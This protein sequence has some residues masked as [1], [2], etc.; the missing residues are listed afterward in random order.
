MHPRLVRQSAN[1][2]AHPVALIA[3]ALLTF[4]ATIAQRLWPSWWTGKLGDVAWLV[5]TPLLGALAAGLLLPRRVSERLGVALGLAVPGLAFALVKGWPF[6]NAWAVAAL[7]G[8]GFE[9]KLAYDPTDLIA[10]PVLLLTVWIW[11]RASS[12]PRSTRARRVSAAL[13]ASLALLADSPAP[14]FFGANCVVDRDGVLSVYSQVEE[15]AY[16][17]SPDR[18]WIDVFTSTD[19]GASWT[20]GKVDPADQTQE[21]ACARAQWPLPVGADVGVQLYQVSGQGI[22]ISDDEGQTLRLEQKLEQVYSALVYEPNGALI[23]AAGE[24]GLFVRAADGLW[25]HTA[26]DGK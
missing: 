21:L 22:Y 9:P 20:A 5:V 12:R 8:L 10:M 18:R 14:L 3:A 1:A 25:T 6:A 2:L 23:I 16:F 15:Y 7:R 13:L 19:G 26:L 24:E 11:R 4:N 17:R